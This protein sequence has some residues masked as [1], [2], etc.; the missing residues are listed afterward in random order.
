M[1]KQYIA[2]GALAVLIF[3][4]NVII[5]INLNEDDETNVSTNTPIPLVD[6]VAAQATPTDAIEVT[7]AV[8]PSATATPTPTDTAEPTATD[9]P[10]ATPTPAPTD[11]AEPTAT[12]EATTTNT[13]APTDTAEPT[14]TDEPTAT[15]TLAPTDTAEPTA[16]NTSAP[17]DTA[18]PTATNTLAPTDTAEPTATNTSAPTATDEPT[19]T[20]TSAPTDTAEPTVTN[21]RALTDTAE[22]TA[23]NTPTV[24]PTPRPGN[25]LGQVRVTDLDAAC[26]SLTSTFDG[27][28]L[29]ED[30]SLIEDG[31]LPLDYAEGDRSPFYFALGIEV[32][33]C[34]QT[35]LTGV[36]LRDTFDGSA[37]PIDVETDRTVLITPPQLEG[38][39]LDN[40]TLTW[41]IG[42]LPVNT[43]VS[44]R[45]KV[46]TE[47]NEAGVLAPLTGETVVL[48]NGRSDV[49]ESLLLTADEGV[50]VVGGVLAVR[51]DEAGECSDLWQRVESCTTVLTPLPLVETTNAG[52][53]PTCEAGDPGCARLVIYLVDENER[54]LFTS[55]DPNGVF[56]FREL[57]AGEYTVQLRDVPDGYTCV[58]PAAC[59]ATV[60]IEDGELIDDV[61]F[62][63]APTE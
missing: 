1:R 13:P 10:T 33:N 60:N 7:P 4:V 46:G 37:Q 40:E 53:V 22:P 61:T 23:T 11:T 38:D 29:T 47:A 35:R 62:F 39:G 19:A 17:T 34:G 59:E 6:P 27:P 8:E 42:A 43:S 9:E 54:T 57:P 55:T 48:F 3:A 32:E 44:L 12:D 5:L 41:L 52:L 49:P 20:N 30:D 51:F 21:T 25:V 28:Y 16:T 24:T 14:A 2:V 15:N 58:E 18:E 26:L 56:G 50:R 45:L 31:L 63:T 36:E